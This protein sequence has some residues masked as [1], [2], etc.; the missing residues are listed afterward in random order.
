MPNE[1]ANKLEFYENIFAKIYGAIYILDITTGGIHWITD[2]E[3]VQN[4]LGITADQIIGM[5]EEF[6]KRLQRYPDYNESMTD[7]IAFFIENPN[8]KWIGLYRIQSL[9][10]TYRW[11]MYSTSAF[12]FA[13]NGQLCKTITMAID[14]TREINTNQVLTQYIRTSLHSQYEEIH[15]QLSKREKEVILH[16]VQGKT[17]KDIAN[18]LFISH[19]T[20]ESHKSNIFKKL[21]IK[22]SVE[23]THLAEKIGLLIEKI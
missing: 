8:T 2:N 19:H 14:V 22:S 18:D 20:V 4:N 17:T 11:V 10:G 23:L 1:N 5:G 6:P 13:D 3:T 12:E 16:I 9:S 15:S 21:D 7:A